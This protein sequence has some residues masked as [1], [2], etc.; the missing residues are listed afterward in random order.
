[1]DE[2][3]TSLSPDAIRAQLVEKTR[4][5][6]SLQREIREKRKQKS[7]IDKK[8]YESDLS[9]AER[10]RLLRDDAILEQELSDKNIRLE[11][12]RNEDANL[13]ARLPE[14]K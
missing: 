4:E 1:M 7:E 2:H 9:S 8:L 10:E 12:L 13:E 3:A 14:V 11:Y 5:I 6:E